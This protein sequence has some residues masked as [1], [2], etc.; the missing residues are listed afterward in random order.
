MVN[1]MLT[2]GAEWLRDQSDADGE[3]SDAKR[4]AFICGMG[5]VSTELEYEEDPQ[6][7]TIYKRLEV[8]STLPDPRARQS[9][10][11]DARFIRF[12]DKLSRDEFEGLYGDVEGVFE[13]N[14]GIGSNNRDPRTS[15]NGE[16]QDGE[17]QDDLITVDLWQWY[18]VDTVVVAQSLDG[19]GVVEYSREEF[20]RVNEALKERGL[21]LEHVTRRRRRYMTALVTGKTFLQEPRALKFNKFTLQLI[22][23]KRDPEKGV[24]YGLVRPMMDPQRWANSFFSM[25]LHMV[26][27]NA[28]GGY[29]YEAG[30]VPDKKKFQ[31]SVAKSDE[32]TE[33]ED[34]ALSQG[35]IQ[36]KSPPSYPVGID[37]LMQQ[38]IDAIRDVTGVNAEML[39]LADRDQ[40]GVLE[41]QRKQA[42]YGLLATFFES[43]RRYRKM[44]GELLL[45]YMKML[46]PETLVRVT[47]EDGIQ[48]AYVQLQA[49]LGGPDAKYDVIVDEMPAGP[50][51]K[52]RTWA[53]IVQIV[54]AIKDQI[55]P[56][57]WAEFLKFSPF[58]E[59]LSIKLREMIMTAEQG[60][61]QQII[62]ALVEQVQGM[63]A[64]M[65]QAGF[66]MDMQNKASEIRKRDADTEQT[67]VETMTQI[68]RPDPEPQVIM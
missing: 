33:L 29:F 28:K 60:Q 59:S 67:Q 54:P 38:S 53:M 66:Q 41:A 32:M 5:A 16:G 42:A 22:T 26:R 47:G 62:Q 1:E 23:G 44:N 61:Q 14:D 11:A 48:Q 31:A 34:G 63:Q 10:A 64:Q 68:M 7:K 36:P 65:A 43:F 17:Q 50:N 8:G 45:E 58:P 18:E 21:N 39:G 40:P 46:G 12:R 52:E 30:A 55:S 49:V 24:W 56:E 2:E 13:P 35:R 37:R 3:E 9:N 15:Y 27:T 57:M 6:G 4:D 51:Q 20:E 19:T 25:L